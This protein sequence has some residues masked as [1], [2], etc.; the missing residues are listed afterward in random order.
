MKSGLASQLATRNN[1]ASV[2]GYFEVNDFGTL[3]TTSPSEC[4]TRGTIGST[5]KKREGLESFD[6]NT[7]ECCNGL[8]RGKRRR[9][10]D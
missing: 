1:L 9:V 3:T 10:N 4:Y 8:T 2:S 6:L 5:G 7:T